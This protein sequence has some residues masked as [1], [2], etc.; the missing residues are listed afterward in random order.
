MKLTA[1]YPSDLL[2]SEQGGK[3]RSLSSHGVP[4]AIAP[5]NQRLCP[6]VGIAVIS[7]VSSDL[8]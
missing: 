6:I 1:P 2:H 5:S 8:D 4:Q 7:F 3:I